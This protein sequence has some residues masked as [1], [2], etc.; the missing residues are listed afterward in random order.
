MLRT[1][2]LFTIQKITMKQI[3]KVSAALAVSLLTIKASAQTQ[4]KWEDIDTSGFHK[5][6]VIQKKGITLTIINKDSLFNANTIQHMA[7]VFWTVYPEE[8]KRFNKKSSRKVTM[9]I[10]DDYKGVAATG[11]S[12]IKIDEAY[13]TAHPEDVDVITHE[14]M[15][16]VQAYN[17]QAET[18]WLSEGIADYVRYTYGVN[19]KK[20][21]WSL[22]PYRAGQSY[23]N[24]YRI[25]ARFL[26]WLEQR[27]RRNLVNKLDKAMRKGTYTADMWVKLTGKNVDELWSEY[28]A[29]PTLSQS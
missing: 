3:F 23:H 18:L 13:M 17:F 15:H 20:A 28:I 12:I 21:G 1:G 27:K 5:T 9:L 2:Y 16:I 25:S 4:H 7:D 19:N 14:A 11:N 6:E 22:P 29:D 24:S 26:V 10:S 8:M